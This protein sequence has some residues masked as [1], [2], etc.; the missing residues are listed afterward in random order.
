E[1]RKTRQRSESFGDHFTQATIF[2]NSQSPTEK[3]HLINAFHFEVG[4]VKDMAVR[5][6][7]VDM[8]TNVDG[9]LAVEVAKGVGV[10]P[11]QVS[12]E[13]RETLVDPALSMERGEEGTAKTRKVAILLD[14]GVNA[15]EVM[16]VRKALEDAGVA[17]T[18]VSMYLGTVHGA[19][20]GEIEVEQHYVSTASV[21]FD[22]VYVPGGR[23]SIDS[24]KTHGEALHFVSEAFKHCKPVAAMAEGVELL[25]AASLPGVKLAGARAGGKAVADQGVVT[26]PAGA[27]IGGFASQFIEAIA[28]HRHWAREEKGQVPA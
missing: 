3:Q 8:L 6:R 18:T 24:L 15:A 14:Q 23:A 13:P 20:G 25:K 10:E 26:A 9:Y 28:Q 5:K 2:W 22:A 19:D 27:D 12:T 11:P 1:G 7:M 16:E 17:T 4:K 21:L